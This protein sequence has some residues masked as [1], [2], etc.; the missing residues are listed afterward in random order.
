MISKNMMIEILHLSNLDDNLKL[1][2]RLS[3]LVHFKIYLCN[4]Y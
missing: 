1:N 3:G 4:Y 2:C